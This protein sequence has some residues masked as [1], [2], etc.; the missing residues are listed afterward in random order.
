MLSSL[1]NKILYT[2]AIFLFLGIPSYILAEESYGDIPS[3][4]SSPDDGIVFTE[5]NPYRP[6]NADGSEIYGIRVQNVNDVADAFGA[7]NQSAIAVDKVINNE[8]DYAIRYSIDAI[9]TEDPNV[10]A[11]ELQDVVFDERVSIYNEVN[12]ALFKEDPVNTSNIDKLNSSVDTSI[13]RIEVLLE[14]ES[15]VALDTSLQRR[16]IS[17]A[18]DRYQ[19]QVE[20]K[21]EIIDNRGGSLIFKDTDEDGLSDYDEAYIYGTDPEDAFTVLGDLNDSQKVISGIDPLSEDLNKV[22]YEDPKTAEIVYISDLY[23]VTEI[24]LI[25]SEEVE[26]K[27]KVVLKGR[28][29]PNSLVTLYIFSTPI[30]VTVKADLSGEW[31][32]TLDQELENGEHEVYVT[33]VDNSGRIIARSNPIP[34]TKSAD[35]ATIGILGEEFESASNTSLQSGLFRNNLLLVILSVLLAGVILT[36]MF[37]GRNTRNEVAHPEEIFPD[38]NKE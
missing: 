5:R 32:F 22:V 37:V 17:D 27:D 34:F 21:K 18:L 2:S 3:I 12:L 26:S 4:G 9:I 1:K 28:A 38:I 30:V 23:K 19:R 24:E 13:Q 8:I 36:L 31:V 25:K 7:I 6:I 33:T 20:E 14:N 35:A 29:L 10:K 11:F 15:G 16:N